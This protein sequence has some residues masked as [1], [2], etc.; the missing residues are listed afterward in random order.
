MAW[1]QGT[2]LP[3][4]GVQVLR[5]YAFCLFSLSNVLI[6]SVPPPV[7]SLSACAARELFELFATFFLLLPEDLEYFVV[8]EEAGSVVE[9]LRQKLGSAR[10]AMRQREESEAHL[11]VSRCSSCPRSASE[12]TRRVCRVYEQKRRGGAAG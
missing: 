4:Y 8:A 10:S 9:S 6:A 2:D 3:R 11:H 12:S 1:K 7:A 5:L